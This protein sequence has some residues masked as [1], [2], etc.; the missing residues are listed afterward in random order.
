MNRIFSITGGIQIPD[1]TVVYPFLN[2]KDATSGLPWD[3]VDAFSMSAGDIVPK[4][5]SKIHVM[6][7]VTQVTF[8]LEGSI[9]VWMKDP[10]DE[11]PYALK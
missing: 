3:L 10:D 4:H 6:P 8:V 11:E 9:E 7:V 1:G 2:S 5:A